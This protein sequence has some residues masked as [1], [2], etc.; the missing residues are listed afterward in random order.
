M[1]RGL[2]GFEWVDAS[3]VL[4]AAKIVKTESYEVAC[5]RQAQLLNELAMVDAL[6]ALRPGVRQ[7]DLSAVFLRRVFELGASAGRQIH[8]I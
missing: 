7:I 8:P 2:S 3:G 5:I 6:R 4:G 1:L